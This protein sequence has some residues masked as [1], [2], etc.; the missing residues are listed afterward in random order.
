MFALVLI[1]LLYISDKQAWHEVSFFN[2][3]V[4]LYSLTGSTFPRCIFIKLKACNQIW[5]FT[6]DFIYICNELISFHSSLLCKF[7]TISKF[8]RINKSFHRILLIFSGDVS[9]NP[10]PAHNKSVI[11]WYR[12]LTKTLCSYGNR[13]YF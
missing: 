6:L 3:F 2:C 12:L 13:K 8:K 1:I 4:C 9:L 11:L 5:M 10:G 7:Y